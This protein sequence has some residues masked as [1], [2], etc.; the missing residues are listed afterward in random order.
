M[1]L[2]PAPDFFDSL[3]F[4]LLTAE[5]FHTQEHAFN[6][7]TNNGEKLQLE[8]YES[9]V[10]ESADEVFDIVDDQPSTNAIVE[11]ADDDLNTQ[12]DDEESKAEEK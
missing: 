12:D 9:D 11:V 3:D 10:D 5:I 7:T 2:M 8:W 6:C 1:E 4:N